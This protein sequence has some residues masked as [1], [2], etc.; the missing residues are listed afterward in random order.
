MP[1]YV[2]GT[3][4]IDKLLAFVFGCVFVLLML[5]LALVVPNPT[6]FTLFVFRVVLALAAAGIG[7]VLPGL[8]EVK[9]PLVRAGG[10]LAL[11]AVVYFVNPPT[12]LRD[13]L[14]QKARASLNDAYSYISRGNIELARDYIEKSK[15]LDPEP[16]DVPFLLAS[17]TKDFMSMI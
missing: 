15:I 8:F 14:E 11:A 12:L 6:E 3:I 10:A 1:S 4:E 17:Y 7:A 5:V 9:L 16:A 2:S 13:S